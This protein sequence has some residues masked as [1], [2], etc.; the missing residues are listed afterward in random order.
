[1]DLSKRPFLLNIIVKTLPSLI[2]NSEAKKEKLT[3]NA[4][5]LYEK[6]TGI[7]L[8]RENSKGKTLIRKEDKLHFCIY[9]I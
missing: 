1:M 8:D 9:S 5:I 4:A 2:E 7:W 6:Y 3:I